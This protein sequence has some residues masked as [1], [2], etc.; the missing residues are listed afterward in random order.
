LLTDHT[1]VAGIIRK[2]AVLGNQVPRQCGIATFTT[3][4]AEAIVAGRQRASPATILPG[5]V[6]GA[7]VAGGR[8]AG[9]AT[10]GSRFPELSSRGYGKQTMMMNSKSHLLKPETT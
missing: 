1:D 2:I 10:G 6:A 8:D 4:F 9:L 5:G 7:G 3:D